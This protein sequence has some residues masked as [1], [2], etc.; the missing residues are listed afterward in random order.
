MNSGFITQNV[1][2]Y[3]KKTIVG[4]GPISFKALL[5]I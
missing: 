2:N 3:R 4:Q 1:S 5:V